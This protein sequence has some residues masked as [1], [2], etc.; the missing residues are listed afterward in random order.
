MVAGDHAIRIEASATHAGRQL[1]D[2]L[3]RTVHV[4]DT[5][6]GTLASSFDALGTD[7]HPQGGDGLT[8][9][10]VTD[11]G[12][13]RLIAPLR[14]LAAS[15]SARFDAT[16]A[17]E[18]ARAL[19]IREFDVPAASLPTTG[20]DPA[21]YQREDG[22]ALLPYGSADLFLTARAALVAGS[23]VD[24]D[25]L[26]AAFNAQL[27]PE[28]PTTRERQITA[29]AG[30]AGIGDDVL[31]RLAAFDAATL[32]VREQLCLALAFAASGDEATA[33]TIEA[34]VLEASGQ[35]LGPWVR[36]GVGTSLDDSLEASGLLLLLAAR[37]GDP[38]AN[39]VARYLA[40]QPS[41]QHVF[42]LEQ[43][44]YVQGMLE[45]LP[46]AAG[47]FAWT[48]DGQRHEE[49]LE[50]GGASTL[51]LTP[52]QRAGFRLEPLAG[53]L[54]VATSWLASGGTLPADPAISVTRTVTPASDAPDDHL[55]R[56][57]LNVT[58][59]AQAPAGCYRL[60]DLLPSGLSPVVAGAAWP[61]SDTEVTAIRPYEI[62][63]QRV[64][65]CV[66]R[67]DQTHSYVYSARVVTPGTYRWE[68][69]VVQSETAPT[70][71]S[72]TPAT[73]YT[74]R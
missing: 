66:G 30:L 47:K 15:T 39:A 62:E 40:D 24:V 60:T 46:R 13:G 36:L 21:R 16:A 4:L 17:A 25:V 61:D 73:T 11:A 65:W 64:S 12:R 32:T 41:T 26:R 38:I 5:R 57:T 50:L 8:T 27:N 67:F 52:S 72:S 2:V 23:V 59:G 22:T 51:V 1:S 6:L 71:G 42:P 63:G 20:F 54:A 29:L 19:L 7:F 28:E 34:N 33:R 37:L 70:V 44:A 3:I 31:G 49:T 14:D 9:Y 74:I 53:Q 35:R 69:A 58:F 43:L 68:P 18:V 55:V 45:R 10:V 56:V 48:V